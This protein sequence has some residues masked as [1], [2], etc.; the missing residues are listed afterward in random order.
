MPR[1]MGNI[2]GM[3]KIFKRADSGDGV[4]FIAHRGPGACPL[5]RS[6]R[7]M[8]PLLGITEPEVSAGGA[9]NDRMARGVTG[10]TVAYP[11]N[12]PLFM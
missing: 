4:K 11:T 1:F 12:Q 6:P 2:C 7:S 5:V 8:L 3:G 9:G 10:A